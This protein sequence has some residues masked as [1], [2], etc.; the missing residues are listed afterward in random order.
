MPNVNFL[1]LNLVNFYY[2]PLTLTQDLYSYQTFLKAV[3]WYK[4]VA[5]NCMVSEF[6]I[7][8]V[9][10]VM[11]KIQFFLFHMYIAMANCYSVIIMYKQ[12]EETLAS[13]CIPIHAADYQLLYDLWLLC[14][15]GRHWLTSSRSWYAKIKFPSDN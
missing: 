9:T 14:S 6:I 15:F 10:M 2:L 7:Y 12:E 1:T 4:R 5:L 3:N 13:I 11:I 8:L